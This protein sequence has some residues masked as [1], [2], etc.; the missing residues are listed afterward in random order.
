M[1]KVKGKEKGNV[2][3][4]VIG[5][6]CIIILS[7]LGACTLFYEFITA[8][9]EA[10]QDDITLSNLATYKN[11]DMDAL[12]EDDKYIKISDTSGAFETFKKH[13]KTNMKLDDNFSGINGSIANGQVNIEQFT[14]YNV[15]DDY[16][17]I[18]SYNE[19][20]HMF[21]RSEVMDKSLTAVKTSNNSIV[22]NTAINATIRFDINILFGQKKTV[23][24]SVDTDIVK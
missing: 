23:R 11:I 7:S 3:I 5:L 10:V 8:R 4:A 1:F 16:V 18:L 17:E 21:I 24:V 12:A 9:A 15:K 20:N 6:M 22:K 13:L 14:I 2:G 19:T